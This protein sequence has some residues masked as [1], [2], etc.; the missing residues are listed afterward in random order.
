MPMRF[1]IALFNVDSMTSRYLAS[2]STCR[3]RRLY[4]ELGRMFMRTRHLKTYQTDSERIFRDVEGTGSIK[5]GA[6]LR[7][8]ILQHYWHG[9]HPCYANPCSQ[10]RE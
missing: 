4:Q 5:F 2:G 1:V 8:R 3:S 6:G 9:R 10:T 7:G